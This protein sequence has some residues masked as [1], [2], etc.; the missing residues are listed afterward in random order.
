MTA[1]GDSATLT[2]RLYGTLAATLLM[3]DTMFQGNIKVTSNDPANPIV[4]IPVSL[5][6]LT[7]VAFDADNLPGE[8]V[9]YQNYPNPFNPTTTISYGVPN[10][11]LVQLNVYDILGRK[12]A[13]L[14]NEEMAPGRHEVTWDASGMASGVFFY[15]LVAGGFVNTKKVTLMR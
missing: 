14:V 2:A 7:D 6:V 9:L 4:N 5:S 10:R 3:S 8:F 11:G 15:R 13:T 12:V 1:P